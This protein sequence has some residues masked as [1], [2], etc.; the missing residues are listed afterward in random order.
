VGTHQITSV[1]VFGSISGEPDTRGSDFMQSYRLHSRFQASLTLAGAS[2][3]SVGPEN[4]RFLPH[5][6]PT[7]PLIRSCNH[8]LPSPRPVRRGSVPDFAFESSAGRLNNGGVRALLL[9]WA[10]ADTAEAASRA[11]RGAGGQA[12]VARLGA[13]PRGRSLKLFSAAYHGRAENG[14]LGVD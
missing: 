2:R 1:G 11:W 4:S 5:S 8:T 14:G 12:G 9:R 13:L 3:P 7:W 10:C 6:Q